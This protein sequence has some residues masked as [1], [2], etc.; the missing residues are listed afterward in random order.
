MNYKW[1]FVDYGEFLATSSNKPVRAMEERKGKQ[2][3]KDYGVARKERK[4]IPRIVHAKDRNLKW[5]V[6]MGMSLVVHWLCYTFALAYCQKYNYRTETWILPIFDFRQVMDHVVFAVL[7]YCDI[8]M[9]YVFGTLGLVLFLGAPYTPIFDKPYFAT[10]LR[11]FWSH[12]WS[13]PIK[14]T[15][16]RIVFTPLLNIMDQYNSSSKTKDQRFSKRH[17]ELQLAIATLA[18]FLFSSLFHEYIM[19]LLMPREPLGLNTLFFMLHGVLCVFQVSMQRITGY[20]INWG[21]G[22]GWSVLGWIATMITL[23]ITCPL[24]VGQYARSGVMMQFPVSPIVLDF[25]KT[26][27]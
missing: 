26:I 7:F 4:W 27:V 16:H 3:S 13:Y 15:F 10:S 19:V 9:S 20:G 6:S 17:S 12:R 8:Q 2:A 25:F 11:D 23:L 14:L 21:A 24:F 5:F 1:S 18:S 22:P